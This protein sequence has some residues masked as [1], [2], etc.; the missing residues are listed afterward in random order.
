MCSIL[1]LLCHYFL[2]QG[3]HKH[4]SFLICC[5]HWAHHYRK[6]FSFI[7]ETIFIQSSKILKSLSFSYLYA[8]GFFIEKHPITPLCKYIGLQWHFLS[9]KLGL[10]KCKIILFFQ[11]TVM[12]F[13]FCFVGLTL[14]GIEN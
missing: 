6:L 14:I 2:V 9:H 13:P 7:M 8:S 5:G 3:H 4:N 11:S 1:L 12:R 10:D